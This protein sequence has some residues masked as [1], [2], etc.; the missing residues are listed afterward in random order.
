MMGGDVC[1][2]AVVGSPG[3]GKT[4][5]SRGLAESLALPLISLDDEYW[6]SGLD[7]PGLRLLAGQGRRAG[8][9]RSVV[10]VPWPAGVKDWI[11]TIQVDRQSAHR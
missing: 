9:G 4:R 3:S 5:L 1:R 6:G 8:L 2:V 11:E 7:P 10:A